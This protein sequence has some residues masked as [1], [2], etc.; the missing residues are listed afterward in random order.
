MLST[1]SST[2]D[3]QSIQ[4]TLQTKDQVQGRLVLDVVVTE[5]ATIIQQ[6]ASKDQTLHVGWN[7]RSVLSKDTK[8]SNGL[9]NKN[10]S[11]A[12]WPQKDMEK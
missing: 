11:T 8:H 7:A 9:N 2:E 10:T 5:G 1:P 4:A 6:A 3:Q 12:N